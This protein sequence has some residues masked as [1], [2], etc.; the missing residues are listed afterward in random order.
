M[1]VGLRK[2]ALDLVQEEEAPLDMVRSLSVP[3]MFSVV[4]K[5]RAQGRAVSMTFAYGRDVWRGLK[6]SCTTS[7]STVTSGVMGRTT[8]WMAGLMNNFSIEIL[9]VV[10]VSEILLLV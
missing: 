2:L 1:S 3:I 5:I 9:L 4:R 10:S 7:T 8:A 6:L